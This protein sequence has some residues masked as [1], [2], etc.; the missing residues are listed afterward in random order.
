MKDCAEDLVGTD[1]QALHRRIHVK[2]RGGADTGGSAHFRDLN[3]DFDRYL[4]LETEAGYRT[5]WI[6]P[7]TSGYRLTVTTDAALI[8][9]AAYTKLRNMA[10]NQVATHGWP[11][12]IYFNADNIEVENV[13]VV[14]SGVATET[15]AI[16]CNAA[17]V[18]TLKL[19]NVHGVS[20]ATGGQYG[21]RFLSAGASDSVVMNNCSWVSHNAYGMQ[22][23]GSGYSLVAKNCIFHGSPDFA[24]FQ[25]TL[26]AGSTHNAFCHGTTPAS[27]ADW[28]DYTAYG[29]LVN[30]PSPGANLDKLYTDPD[31]NFHLNPTAGPGADGTDLSADAF[32]VTT[33]I[34]G[35]ARSVYYLGAFP[36]C[37]ISDVPRTTSIGSAG[38][39]KRRRRRIRRW[40]SIKR[41]KNHGLDY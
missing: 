33:H 15:Y 1:L 14:S 34:D 32:P 26:S 27:G 28:V 19:R 23:S 21:F 17:N 16:A 38:F 7:F 8:I 35:T 4:I 39:A 12:G 24:D 6:F 37:S 11:S 25:A 18:N 41:R 10:V 29:Q 2:C 40:L 9:S 5:P 31:G 13:L 22:F 20:L 30:D 3:P 36:Q